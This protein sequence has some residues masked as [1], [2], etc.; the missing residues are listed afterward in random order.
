MKCNGKR[1]DLEN[2]SDAH[3]LVSRLLNMG[4]DSHI[5][6]NATKQPRQCIAAIKAHNTMG[7]YEK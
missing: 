5:L 7:T 3:R 6:M 2:G 4:V 1:I